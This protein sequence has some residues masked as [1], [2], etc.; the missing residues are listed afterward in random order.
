MTSRDLDIGGH[1]AIVSGLEQQW[2]GGIAGQLRKRG[3]IV[4]LIP[5]AGARADAELVVERCLDQHGRVDILMSAAW[6]HH[7]PD[8]LDTA[9]AHLL[10][11]WR[12]VVVTAFHLSQAVLPHMASRRYGRIVHV[13]D[14]AGL[15]YGHDGDLAT[16]DMTMGA[17]NAM[18]RAIAADAKADGVA[19]NSVLAVPGPT[20]P[21]IPFTD[22]TVIA[23]AAWLAG[24]GCDVAS[25]YFAAGDG[26]MSEVLPAWGAATRAPTRVA[27][28]SRR[29]VITGLPRSHSTEALHRPTRTS[30]SSSA[31]RSSMQPSDEPAARQRPAAGAPVTDHNRFDGRVAVVSGA[32]R[33]LGREFAILLAERGAAVVVNDIGVSGDAN[34]Y[35]PVEGV[36]ADISADAIRADVAQ[37][38]VDQI[39]AGGGAAVANTADISDPLQAKTIVDDA[40]GAFGRIDVVINNA[41]VV[42][43]H[44]FPDLS[45]EDLRLTHAVHVLGATSILRAAIPHMQR[46]GY[47]RVVNISSVEGGLIGTPHFE[48]Y[49]AAKGAL[50]GLTRNLARRHGQFGIQINAVLPSGLTRAALRSGHQRTDGIDRSTTTVAPPVAWLCHEDCDVTGRLIAVSASSVRQVY[51]TVDAGYRTASSL[52]VE[53]IG[54][55]WGEITA[56]GGPRRVEG[57]DDFRALWASTQ[58]GVTA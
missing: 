25:R 49:A 57:P 11:A 34:R 56:R 47:G 12:D 19:A 17:L 58:D 41:G 20:D 4:E 46:Q 8:L 9:D 27:S 3:A 6:P 43:T 33:G 35:A 45:T 53:D 31:P 55:H 23:A 51:N 24:P 14:G 16:Y 26:R 7:G 42:I 22:G 48:A 5:R 28:A 44:P 39:I 10:A 37:Q 54:A 38:V 13:A 30:T 40:I 52:S 50:I 32:G 29:F 2:A 21:A 15:I 18:M 1:V 36:P